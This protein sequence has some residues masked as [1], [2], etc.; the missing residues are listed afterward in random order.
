MY[1]IKNVLDPKFAQTQ[2]KNDIPQNQAQIQKQKM[3]QIQQAKAKQTQMLEEQ[4]KMKDEKEKY[5]KYINALIKEYTEAKEYFKKNG[6]SFEKQLAKAR[7][8]FAILV[9]AKQKVDSN[10]YKEIKLNTLPKQI[11]PEYIF[12]YTE[13]E[14]MEK[15]KE[16]L[17]Q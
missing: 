10:K 5:L 11:T 14:R 13:K 1:V 16:V 17:S 2:I 9:K 12:G 15:F 6:S 3:E 7:N 8:D 4:K